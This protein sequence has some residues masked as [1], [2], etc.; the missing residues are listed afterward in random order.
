MAACPD[1]ALAVTVLPSV[2]ARLVGPYSRL[3]LRSLEKALSGAAERISEQRCLSVLAEYADPSGR[4]LSAALEETGLDGPGY[5]SALVF[6]D[7]SASMPCFRSA[8]VAWTSPG[9]R[10]VFLCGTR[11]AA[12]AHR[13]PEYASIILIHEGLHTLGLSENP[14]SSAEINDRIGRRCRP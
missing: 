7:G 9:S 2:Q 10:A 3:L 5:L 11:F 4:R 12:L 14:P 6:L 13:D 1:L 8:T